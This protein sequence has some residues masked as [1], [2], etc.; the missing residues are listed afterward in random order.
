MSILVILGLAFGLALDR[1]GPT[2]AN[3]L[4]RMLSLKDLHLAKTILLGIGLASSQVF[5][6]QM[7]GVVDAGTYVGE[8]QLPERAD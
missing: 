2:N 8:S 7:A 1:V 5:L 4:P 3:I 6:G